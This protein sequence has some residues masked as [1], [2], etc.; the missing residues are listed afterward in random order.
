MDRHKPASTSDDTTTDGPARCG[1]VYWSCSEHAVCIVDETGTAI[2]QVTVKHSAIRL[3][4][5]T[6]LL[7]RHGVAEVAI[8]RGDG[9]VV[10]A[11]LDAG[12]TLFLIASRQVTALRSPYGAAG[13][14]RALLRRRLNPTCTPLGRLTP[15]HCSPVG[16]RT[17]PRRRA[18]AGDGRD[19]GC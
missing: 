8:E 6:A 10:Q 7:H 5:L 15:G 3:S 16:S 18:G 12:Q 19:A 9:P 11:L 4:R 14:R 13:H 2:E 17:T 1:G